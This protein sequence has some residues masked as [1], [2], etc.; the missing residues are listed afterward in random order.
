MTR[1]ARFNFDLDLAAG[2]RPIPTGLPEELV[3][4]LVEDAR[5][6]GFA[7]GRKQGEQAASAMAAQA[8]AAAAAGLAARSADMVTALD[9]AR[10]EMLADATQL[11]ASVGRKLAANLIAR[12]PA[13]ELAALIAECLAGLD[14]APH[15]VIRCHPDLADTVRDIATEQMAHSGFAGRLVVLGDPEFRLGDGRIEWVDGGV[16]RDIGALSAEIDK[17]IASYLS[18]ESGQ[19]TTEARP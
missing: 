7:E 1:P 14:K 8:I 5:A 9:K 3:A 18:A 2:P 12:E 4:R 13:A 19:P 6:A 11:A 10:N 15:L 17:H 16:V